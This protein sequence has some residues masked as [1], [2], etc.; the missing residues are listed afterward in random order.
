MILRPGIGPGEGERALRL[1]LDLVQALVL[2]R[3]QV[4]RTADRG[5]LDDGVAG[6][7]ERGAKLSAGEAFWSFGYSRS[8]IGLLLLSSG[9]R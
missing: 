3:V 8:P 7:Q 2:L 5:L 4:A 6:G 1:E 9:R